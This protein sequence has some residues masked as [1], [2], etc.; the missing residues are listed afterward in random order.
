MARAFVPASSVER[1][2]NGYSLRGT[3]DCNGDDCVAGQQGLPSR[4][5][6]DHWP[7]CPPPLISDL[8]ATLGREN[9]LS[10]PSELAV[11]DCDAF[12][13][14]RHR[15]DAVVFPRSTRQVAEVVKLCQQHGAPMVARGAGT[16][17]AGGCLPSAAAWWSCSRG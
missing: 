1:V 13:I 3:S 2:Q 7:L 16:S 14:E 17:L 12:T 8:R 6:L 15:P 5:T 9:V 4:G 10:A 11:Y